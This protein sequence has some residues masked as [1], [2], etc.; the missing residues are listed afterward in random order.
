MALWWLLREQGIHESEIVEILENHSRFLAEENA[1][2]RSRTNN[3][4]WYVVANPQVG[5]GA[6]S[7]KRIRYLFITGA[8]NEIYPVLQPVT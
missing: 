6:S 8:C 4:T 2:T 7:K 5:I 3:K 1:V